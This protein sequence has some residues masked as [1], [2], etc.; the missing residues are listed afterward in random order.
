MLDGI[1]PRPIFN[2]K[3]ALVEAGAAFLFTINDSV[4]YGTL[5]ALSYPLYFSI[6]FLIV[7]KVENLFHLTHRLSVF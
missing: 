5:S 4:H 7:M 3:A 1:N 6:T 2:E